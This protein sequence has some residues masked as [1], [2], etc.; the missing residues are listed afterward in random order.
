[1]NPGLLYLLRMGPRARV[2]A[3]RKR[4]SGPSLWILIGMVAIF[5]SIIVLPR[6]MRLFDPEL[7]TRMMERSRDYAGALRVYGPLALLAMGLLSMAGGKGLYFRP[8]E[9]DFLFP[10]PIPRR[11]LL[12]YNVISRLVV[13]LLSSVW[14]SIFAWDWFGTFYG[15]L[16]GVCLSF[17]FVQLLAQVASVLT[18]VLDRRLSGLLR[19]VA[20]AVIGVGAL[21]AYRAASTSL[22]AG[23][24]MREVARE[25]L[26]SPVIAVISM[27]TRPFIDTITAPTAAGVAIH[28]AL[29]VAVLGALLGLLLVF[30]AAFVEASLSYSRK[31][32]ARLERMKSGGGAFGT[33]RA[34]SS[35][36]MQL[37]NFP[38]LGGAGPLA[39]RHFQEMTRNVR[40]I[41]GLVVMT[42]V[43]AAMF[44]AVGTFAREEAAGLEYFGIGMTLFF[45]TLMTQNCA[46]DF[47]RDIDRMDTLKALPLRPIAV[48]CGQVIPGA[49]LLAL[50]QF[51]ITALVL[52][53]LHQATTERVAALAL[54][55]PPLAFAVTCV[56]NVIFL[57][58]PLRPVNDDPGNLPFLFRTT[59]VMLLK[60][61][62]MGA[63]ACIAFTLGYVV[64]LL[65]GNNLL[66]G[67]AAVGLSMAAASVPLAGLVGLAFRRFDVTRD[68]PA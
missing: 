54:A 5:A 10:A 57:V 64:Y 40:G 7:D 37:P 50:L 52:A 22:G 1:M 32:Q 3:I 45:V 4:F 26:D 59:L 48:A 30:D 51:G 27:P 41:L 21:L 11:Q 6:L 66:L 67:A 19:W 20:L 24:T 34:S 61:G 15:G 63:L 39:R 49:C 43:F 53:G 23:A 16:L 56:D 25:V 65:T 13:Q 55:L 2:R 28:A 14:V 62:A 46:Y 36:S 47:R 42:L 17:T 8:A 33:G 35:R 9:V 31:I 12:L 60:M 58:A 38:R 18:A 68:V 44:V 29:S